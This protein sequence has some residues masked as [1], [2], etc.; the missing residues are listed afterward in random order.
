MQKKIVEVIIDG[1]GF[2]PALEKEILISV[3]DSLS[4]HHKT[5]FSEKIYRNIDIKIFKVGPE[6][7]FCLMFSRNPLYNYFLDEKEQK[8]LNVR[9]LVE[10]LDSSRET[11][12]EFVDDVSSMINDM[13]RE[14]HY[15]VWA[16]KT[17][18]IDNLRKQYPSIATKTSGLDIGYEDI[19]PEVQGNSETGHQQLGNM[20]VAPQIPLEV[21]IDIESGKFTDNKCLNKAIVKALKNKLNLNITIL[22]SGQ[23]GNDGRV[24]SCWDHLEVFLKIVCEKHN[25][26]RDRLRIQAILDGRDA[27]LKS[28]IEDRGSE[29]GFLYALKSL[30]KP[31]DAEDCVAWIIGRGIAM[32][33]DYEEERT[34]KDY[35]LLVSGKGKIVENYDEAVALVQKSHQAQIFDPFIEPIVIKNKQGD[36]RTIEKNDIVINLNF[37]AD[38]QR[39]RI[40]GLLGAKQFL[41]GEAN[42]KNKSWRMDWIDDDLNLSV[43]CLTEYHP[44][45]QEYGAKIAY[46]I[47][48]QPFNF[49]SILSNYFKRK[50]VPFRYLLVAESTKAVHMGYFIRG[51]REYP[52][53]DDSEVRFVI[54]SYAREDGIHTDDDYYKTPQMK[55]FEVAGKLLNEFASGTYD[56]AIINLSNPDMLGHLI[57]EHF[58]ENVRCLEIIDTII[59]TIFEFALKDG[60]NLIL[61]SDHGNIDEFGSS[62]SLNKVITTFISPDDSISLKNTG[63]DYIRLFDIPWAIC[64]IFGIS[65]EIRNALPPIPEWITEKGLNGEVPI[66]VE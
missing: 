2:N 14:K 54:P 38:R 56:L 27:P 35:E 52:E 42:K 21:S 7:V 50:D 65:D 55:A 64:E 25:F 49:L 17:P 10:I 61:T 26:P 62:H 5:I 58:D 15:A 53:I 34:Q 60:F 3:Y 9:D 18:W 43:N 59:G 11:N 22:L 48:E 66:I 20:M 1:Y 41:Q 51:R 36:I 46:P 57:N 44:A 19:R 16:A 23:F 45:L 13:A 32:D 63:R 24:H 33:R 47:R 8:G 4:N 31:F 6:T 39:A 28:S 37:R 30:L 12:S 29:K 40:A